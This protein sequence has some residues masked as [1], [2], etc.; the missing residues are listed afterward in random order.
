M[1]RSTQ[2][3]TVLEEETVLMKRNVRLNK[4]P[5]HT[6]G[7]NPA[8]STGSSSDAATLNR[9]NFLG[10]GASLAAFA[11]TGLIE[12]AVF[13]GY[14][15][16]RAKAA[17][18]TALKRNLIWINMRG[19]WDILESTDPKPASTSGIDMTYDWSA[20]HSL[21]G[22]SDGTKLGRWLPGI[23][24][25]GDEVLVLRGLAM[26]TTSHT[27]GSIYMDTG[28]LSNAGQVNA[29]SIPAIVASESGATIPIIQLSGGSE[30]MIDR[31]LLNPVSVVRAGNLE[32]YR[33]MYPDGPGALSRRTAMLDY[34][35]SSVD[36]AIDRRGNNDR[37]DGLAAAEVKVRAQFADNVGAKLALTDA[38]RDHF[39]SDAPANLR[40]G[41]LDAVAL[42]LKLITSNVSSCIN[43]GFGGFDT[44]SNQTSRLAPLLTGIDHLVSRLAQGLAMANRLD[45]TLIVLYSDFG[46]TPK[47]NRSNGRDHWPVGGA[48]V[49][50][51]GIEGGRSFGSTDDN[52]AAA[53]LIDPS[54]GRL[55]SDT[56]VGVQ[57]N[58]T[59]LGGLVLNLTLGSGYSQ[60][61]P[62][63]PALPGLVRTRV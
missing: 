14:P 39:T 40:R 46:R 52:L 19:G 1:E 49:I 42:T 44:H 9:R 48:I 10:G 38:D 2:R 20:A 17:A 16:L 59:H 21:Q 50:G 29:A 3:L 13:T 32:L 37:L 41:N 6:Q 27:A 5:G 60:Y 25:L 57:L 51:G 45:D 11:S 15:G 34:L 61:R 56:S 31:G 53:E 7:A 22:S 47:V 43:L 18:A 24:S 35:K 26:G 4:K 55:T 62:Y 30:P 33:S 63:L 58:P 36:R 23:A 54:T 12:N 8:G 28:V